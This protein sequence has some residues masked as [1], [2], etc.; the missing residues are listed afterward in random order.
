MPL[1]VLSADAL[2]V[3]VL[4][5]PWRKQS[6]KETAAKSKLVG[7]VSKLFNIFSHRLVLI[8]PP[9]RHVHQRSE[10]TQAR[11]A[12]KKIPP[13]L[14]PCSRRCASRN[15]F[16]HFLASVGVRRAERGLHEE[17][18]AQKKIVQ[19]SALLQDITVS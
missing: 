2:V 15:F 9:P 16:L 5:F 10:R 7:C 14:F 1:C 17:K 11:A 12:T 19:V 18:E 13:R 4:V 8:F 6:G 3:I